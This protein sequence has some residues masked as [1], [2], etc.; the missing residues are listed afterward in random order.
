MTDLNP[1]EVSRRRP[2]GPPAGV[3]ASICLVLVIA[4]A[5]A[6]ASGS[7]FWNGFFAF[8]ASVPL[9][10]YAA[11]VYARLLRLGVRVPGPGIAFFGGVTASI[12]LGLSG[13]LA[14]APTQ[15][16]GLPES[17]FDLVDEVV[18]LL[19][20]LGMATGLGLLISGIAVPALILR[21]VPRWLSVVGLAL[22][23]LGELSFLSMLW[24][25]LDVV[26]PIVR[27]GGLGWLVG[28]GFLL[29]RDRRDVPPRLA[30][31]PVTM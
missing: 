25:G 10:I 14:W 27:F 7:A 8:A 19:G 3:V 29:P 1:G 16:A 30:H 21:L 22:G 12:L 31:Q 24:S 23:L 26:L 11:T 18:F 15:V 9:G 13:L 4:S 28:V 2:D 6:Y 5:S 20:G 17:V